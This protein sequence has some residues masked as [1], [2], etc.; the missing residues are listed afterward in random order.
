[1]ERQATNPVLLYDGDCGFCNR[2][3]A[4]ILKH[5]KSAFLQFA[6]LQSEWTCNYFQ[7]QNKKM[8]DGNSLIVL[9]G[10]TVLEKF[11]AVI[12][13]SKFLKPPYS[14]LYFFRF[15]PT[16]IGDAVY[17]F[18]AKRRHKLGKNYCFLPSENQK[19]RFFN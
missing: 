12:F 13:L 14:F 9:H 18:I 16:R 1:M 7:R 15:I 2:S 10:D 17:D 19:K 6:A 3:V 5:E 8:P 11:S 4:F